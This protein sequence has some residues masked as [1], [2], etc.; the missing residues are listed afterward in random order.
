MSCLSAAV[1]RPSCTRIGYAHHEIPLGSRFLES[2]ENS[3]RTS[4]QPQPDSQ[5]ESGFNSAPTLFGPQSEGEALRLGL[6]G[7][8]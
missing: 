6:F 4:P 1:T 7:T 8:I 2:L 3:V 5:Q